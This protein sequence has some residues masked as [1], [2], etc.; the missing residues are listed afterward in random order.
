MMHNSNST[1]R[2]KLPLHY[3]NTTKHCNGVG[4]ISTTNNSWISSLHIIQ[5]G[6]SFSISYVSTCS[7]RIQHT[8]SSIYTFKFSFEVSHEVQY[9]NNISSSI[10]HEEHIISW[11]FKTQ[12]KHEFSQEHAYIKEIMSSSKHTDSS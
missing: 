8:L 9:T 10:K 7:K 5:K 12:V 2:E 1:T 6:I 3:Q 11:M 4:T